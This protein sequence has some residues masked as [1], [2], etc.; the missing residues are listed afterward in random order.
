[1]LVVEVVV[2]V[3]EVNSDGFPR[4]V[5]H[6]PAPQR[7]IREMLSWGQPE[8]AMQREGCR[9]NERLTIQLMLWPPRMLVKLPM[10]ESTFPKRSGRRNASVNAQIPPLEPL[11]AQ[12]RSF[13]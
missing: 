3:G 11:R 13:V 9:G 6:L 1:M 5:P 4:R 8:T 7:D 10:N 2:A 12:Q